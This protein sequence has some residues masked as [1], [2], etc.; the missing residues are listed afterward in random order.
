MSLLVQYK[1][2]ELLDPQY[3][4]R[5]NFPTEAKIVEYVIRSQESLPLTVKVR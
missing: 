3:V 2:V 1:A 4:V 5:F